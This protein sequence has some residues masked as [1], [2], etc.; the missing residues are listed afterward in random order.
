M[1]IVRQDNADAF[2]LRVSGRLDAYWADHLAAA[3]D[4]VVR[5]G[6][7][8]IRLDLA[9][10]SFMS[11]VG[12]RMLL[13][14]YKQLQR[15]QG[16]FLVV[17]P[18]TAVS[19]V[20]ELAGLGS[21]LHAAATPAVVAPSTTRTY[22]SLNAT[23]E[24]YE[25]RAATGLRCQLV[26]DPTPLGT[27]SF[28]PSHCHSM[29]F[30]DSTF[31]VGLGALGSSFDD[32]RPRFGELVCAGGVTAYAPTDGSNA[33]DY[34]QASGAFV[35][36]LSVLYALVCAGKCNRLMRFDAKPAVGRVPLSELIAASFD[37][38]GAE[39]VGLVM[40]AETAGLLGAALRRSPVVDGGVAP[41]LTHPQ[42]RDWLSF[43]P[44]RA[45]S[46]SSALVV[47]VATRSAVAPLAPLLRPIG[48]GA[49]GHF[50]AAA[51]T[52]RPLQKGAI[53]LGATV[54]ALFASERLQGVLHLIHDDRDVVGSGDSEL[55]RGACWVGPIIDIGSEGR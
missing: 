39:C 34:L 3:L 41:I 2:E 28:T 8:R 54:A 19:E 4:E 15:I 20:L 49:S 11:S 27:A 45:Y 50:H 46:G 51:L 23:Y 48:G 40:V 22:D 52:Y 24:I 5:G 1:E 38:A 44:Q 6:A 12:I 10:I 16:S 30:P 13:R 14:F 37:V 31:A 42:I 17:N 55:V 43:T 53:E 18:S 7:N 36:Q 21:L 33:P 25:D 9:G 32:C 47:G 29:A 26:G 35:P